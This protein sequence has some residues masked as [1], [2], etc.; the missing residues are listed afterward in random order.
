VSGEEERRG[1][2]AAE[3]TTVRWPHRKTDLTNIKESTGC[4]EASE[5]E[6]KWKDWS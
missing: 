1:G 6:T 4:K 3:S 5:T 2:G